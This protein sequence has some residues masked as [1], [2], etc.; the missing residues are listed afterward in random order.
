MFILASKALEGHVI[1]VVIDANFIK[2]T[3]CILLSYF[4]D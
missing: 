3:S 2:N 4:F 1:W